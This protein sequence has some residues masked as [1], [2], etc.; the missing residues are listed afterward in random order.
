M[1]QHRQA[2]QLA[3]ARLGLAL[4]SLWALDSARDA[5]AQA[6]PSERKLEWVAGDLPPFAWVGPKGPQG[7]AHE[8]ATRMA[9]KLGRPPEVSYYPWAR[10]VKMTREGQHYGIFPLAR[11]PDRESQFRWLIPL[12][13]VRY[14]FVGPAG[15]TP[16]SLDQLRT[17]RV[18][19][20]RGSPIINNLRAERF[21]DLVEARDY[22]DLLRLLN[23]DA[24][25]VI[26]AGSPMLNAAIDEYGYERQ[27]FQTH[28]T[29]GEATLYMGASLALSEA[30]AQRWVQA[31][32]LLQ[33]D[34]SVAKL[35]QQY[36]R[37]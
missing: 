32:Q 21:S 3:L 24:I 12:V 25:A 17:Q 11:T 15:R 37:P 27:R 33:A 29:L 6:A 31:Y 36:L 5:L 14:A 13:T 18:G 22:K 34:G 16:Q 9:S 10:A 8:L 23:M 26:Y 28:T 1:N 35:Q 20:L 30:E 19:V 4:L 7:Y 2:P